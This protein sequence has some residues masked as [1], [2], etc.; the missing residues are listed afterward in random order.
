MNYITVIGSRNNDKYD[1]RNI[2]YS[3]NGI[4][5]VH[6]LCAKRHHHCKM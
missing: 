2:D 6:I 5:H 3:K 1:H 4:A